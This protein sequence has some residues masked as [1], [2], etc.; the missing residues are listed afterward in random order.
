MMDGSRLAIISTMRSRN[1]L[2]DQHIYLVTDIV[3]NASFVRNWLTEKGWV[4]GNWVE[5]L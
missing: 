1:I 5:R 2:I 4:G 3:G